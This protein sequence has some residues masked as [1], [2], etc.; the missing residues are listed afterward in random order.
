MIDLANPE[1]DVLELFHSFMKFSENL[2]HRQRYEI[3]LNQFDVASWL[4]YLEV[5]QDVFLLINTWSL[6]DLIEIRT[7]DIGYIRFDPSIT[8]YMERL[9]RDIKL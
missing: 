3:G 5:N 9:L 6:A 7:P 1:T 2:R 4:G 8:N